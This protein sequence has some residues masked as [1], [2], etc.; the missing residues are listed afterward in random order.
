MSDRL[1]ALPEVRAPA[2]VSGTGAD[3]FQRD[4]GRYWRYAR[5]S[6]SLP[7]TQTGW[8]YKSALKGLLAALG[9]PPDAPVDEAG[10]GRVLFMR[11]ALQALGALSGSANLELA[12]VA[13]A[14]FLGLPAIA[15]L[16]MLFDAWRDGAIWLEVD[17]IATPRTA[18]MTSEDPAAE[19]AR[20]RAA[21]LRLLASAAGGAGRWISRDAFFDAVRRAEPGFLLKRKANERHY[22]AFIRAGYHPLAR[23]PYYALNNVFGLTFDVP[24]SDAAWELVEGQTLARLIAGPLRWMG[25]AEIGD[26][27]GAWSPRA[28]SDADAFTALRLTTAG[29]WLLG[30]GPEPVFVEGGGRVIVQPNF[31]IV[32]MDPVADAVL[33]DLDHFAEP[34]G[35]DRAALYE[36]TRQS[37]YRGQRAGWPASRIAS[38]L[39]AHQGGPLPANIRRSL[40]EWQKQ[41]D[42][43]V[44]IR[45]A[46]LLQYADEA[47]RAGAREALGEPAPIALSDRFD[48]IAGDEPFEQVVDRLKESGWMPLITPAGGDEHAGIARVDADGSI[49]LKQAVPSVQALASLDMVAEPDGKGY[50]L[51]AARVRAA[52]GRGAQAEQA[53]ATLAHLADGPLPAEIVDV[54]RGWASYYGEAS[55]RDMAVLTLSH[56]EVLE[57]ALADPALGKLLQPV[58]GALQ[59]IALVE[60]RNIEAVWALLSERGVAMSGPRQP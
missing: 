50:A 24:N 2:R 46:R 36:L 44:F 56:S 22:P 1:A 15:R 42:R 33:I 8:V 3:E 38:Y 28:S 49:T 4:L 57:H 32:A 20:A 11:R 23:T 59:P 12:V 54:I 40:D 48:L 41:H 10:H 27:S 34:R 17:R 52:M 21:A 37:V 18:G 55:L 53:L 5:R 47:A 19:M 39:E 7:M 26:D 60:R 13:D 25:L 51:S 45:D 31:T 58:P 9:E 14:A 29:A 16:R 35:G 6:G 43:I 30:L